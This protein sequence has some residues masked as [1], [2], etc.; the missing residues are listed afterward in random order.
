M[1]FVTYD[2]YCECVSIDWWT[3]KTATKH[4]HNAPIS[5]SFIASLNISLSNIN[6]IRSCVDLSSWH[7]RWSVTPV[8]GAGACRMNTSYI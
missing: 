3:D 2:A 6:L 7:G 8:L 4:N 5:K 1:L